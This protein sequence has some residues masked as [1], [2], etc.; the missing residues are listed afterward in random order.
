MNRSKAGHARSCRVAFCLCKEEWTTPRVCLR[1]RFGAKGAG[2][3]LRPQPAC[4]WV[5]ESILGLGGRR[6]QIRI[7]I[8][9]SG[10]QIEPPKYVCT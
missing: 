3:C 8:G 1:R 4:R 7:G 6:S 10:T 5:R 2:S 9:S